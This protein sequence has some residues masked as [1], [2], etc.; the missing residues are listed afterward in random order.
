PEPHPR[1]R[2]AAVLPALTAIRT[3]SAQQPAAPQT[4]EPADKGPTPAPAPPR[5]GQGTRSEVRTEETGRRPPARAATPTSDSTPPRTELASISAASDAAVIGDADFPPADDTQASPPPARNASPSP[6]D[7]AK[8]G[9]AAAKRGWGIAPIRWGGELSAG[10]RRRSGDESAA[11]TEQVYEARLRVNSYIMQPYIALVSGDIGLTTIRAQ[12]GGDGSAASSNLTGTSINGSG[13]LNLFPQSRFPFQASLGVSDSRSDGSIVA[14]D[15]RRTRLSLRQDYRPMRGSWTTSGQYDRSELDGSFGSDVVNRFTG[16]FNS[17]FDRHSF[18]TNASLSTNDTIEQS[19][20][21]FFILGTHGYRMSDELT[22]NSSASYTHQD[23][24]LGDQAAG[25]GGTTQSAQL[26]SYASWTPEDSNWRGTANVRYFQSRSDIGETSFDSTNLGGSASLSY[27]ASRNLSF[28]GTLGVNSSSNGATSTNQNLG[29]NYTG[30]A[31]TLGTSTMYNWYGSASVS[32]TTST[33]GGSL[34]SN[35]VTFGH[36]VN[37][38]WL[39]TELSTLSGNLNQSLSS[40]RSTGLGAVST[41]SLTNGASLSLQAS[42]GDSLSGFLSTSVSDTRVYGDSPSSYQ[43][44]NVQLSGNWRINA[45][46][47]LYSNLTWQ[48]SR[49]QSASGD[50]VVLTDE[51]GRP[52]IVE[53][54]SKSRNGSLS[55]GLGYGHSRLFGIRGLRYN[56]DFRANTTRD[57]ARRRGDPDAE[58]NPD[59]AT[60]D[61]DQR[62]RYSIGRLDTELQL[63]IAEIEGRRSELLFFRVGRQFGSF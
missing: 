30:D 32:N 39:T 7:R 21:D 63:R 27:Q 47:Q 17:N 5:P 15:T 51:F 60:L 35:S 58:R 14:N 4:P 42:A 62:L 12:T 61:L 48:L 53:D 10:F 18:S 22:F 19:T 13:T 33:D 52:V 54:T 50:R 29:A 38:S 11:S 49:Q 24:E 9:S 40:S 2:L 36:S 1:L 55:G 8:L 26:F 6:A 56:L 3:T 41:N 28:F 31:I 46:S 23:F 45:Y 44:L 37:R 59:R 57:D 34:R 16:T 43:M 20:K 25:L